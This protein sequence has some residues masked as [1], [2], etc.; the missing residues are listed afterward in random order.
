MAKKEKLPELLRN[1]LKVVFCGTAAGTVSAQKRQYYAGPGNKFWK[2]LFD[3]K[4][5]DRIL[6]PSEFYKLPDYGIGLTDL[7]KDQS[8]MDNRIVFREKNRNALFDRIKK[9]QPKILCFNGKRAAQEYF[10]KKV[11]YGLQDESIGKTRLFV[12]PSTSRAA[13]RYWDIKVWRRLARLINK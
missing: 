7:V 3:I 10:G 5:T 4:L 12:A 1:N 9:H 6:L 2:T 13:N 11:D 8:G